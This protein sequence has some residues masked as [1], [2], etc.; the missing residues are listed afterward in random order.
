MYI[1]LNIRTDYSLLHSMIKIKDLVKFAKENDLKALTITDDNMFGAMEFYKECTLNNIK[2]IIGINIIIE[3]D[4]LVL[5]AKNYDGYVNLLKL[6]SI[7]RENGL[8]YDLLKEYNNNLICILP[9]KSR[10]IY[11]KLKDIY[12]DLYISYE[13]DLEKDKI[14]SANKLYMKEILSLKEEDT[15][16]LNYLDAIKNGKL[17]EH[18]KYDNYLIL[19]KEDNSFLYDK[20]DI[21]IDKKDNLLPHFDNS[22]NLLKQNCIDGLK[23]IFGD[24]VGSKYIERLK[25]ELDTINEMGFNDYF[26]IVS[27]YVRFAKENNILVGPGR[28]SAVG[29]LV[30]YVLGITEI[31]PLKYGLLFERFLNNKRITMPDIDIDFDGDKRKLV[32]KYCMDKYGF[33]NVAGVITFTTLGSK[34]VL[35]DVGRTLDIDVKEIEYLGKLLDSNLNLNENLKLDKIKNHLNKNSEL[36]ELYDICLKLEGIKKTT[37]VNASGIIICSQELDNFIPLERHDNMYLSG[38]SMNYLEDIG[39]LK[40]DF[41]ALKNLSTIASINSEVNINLYEIPLD[42]KETFEIFNNSNTLG[43]F[44]FET[45]GMI[46]VLRK[47]KINKFDDLYNLSAIFRPGPKENIDSYIKRKNGLERID[48]FDESLESI[49]KPTYGIIIYQEQIMKIANIMANYTLGEADI[50]RR[51]MSKKKEEILVNEKDKFI[52]RSISN[53]Y[54]KEKSET[55]YNLILKFAEY[56]FNK[57]HSVAYA[58]ISYQMAYLKAHYTD[59]FYK[60][61]LNSVM[62]SISSTKE[63][64]MEAKRLGV[65][66]INPSINLSTDSYKIDNGI[67]LPLNL[68]NGI[69]YNACKMILENRKDKYVDI[70]DFLAKMDL[71]I[72][73][74]DVLTNLILIGCFDEFNI[75]R[76]TLIENL[77]VIYNYI[78]LGS[79]FVL[80]PELIMYDEYTKK[81]LIKYE[82]EIFGFYLNNNPITEYRKDSNIKITLSNVTSYMTRV[83][84]VIVFIDE[85]KEIKSKKNEKMCFV[86]LSDDFSN[87][88]GVIFSNAY[89]EI[90]SIKVNDIVK[91]R[92]KIESRKG[93]TQIIVNKMELLD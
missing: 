49:L 43:I 39:L 34:A 70:Y 21:K 12:S 38:Y 13:N 66:F 44:Q 54:T 15:D 80:R 9:C 87:I 18:N 19:D 36:K 42:D 17:V 32:I 47:Y 11:N 82:F 71:K 83:I 89:N 30:A 81:E 2:P 8:T 25:T 92:G 85:I 40:M 58:L 77:D 74:K 75:N 37:S 84:D 67:I 16:Y 79:D 51:A 57:S 78:E 69:N 10:K 62:G 60:N 76:R 27:D 73:K 53:G 22:Y 56:G 1:P 7:Y 41:L 72:F 59:I 64:I 14:K 33:K 88:D 28:G 5:Y 48:C 46:D 65:K 86:K 50:L 91:V 55:I 35:K 24:S 68:I 29:S 61:L 4:S 93:K 45:D 52:K 6:S 23:R 26:L 3:D 20:I 90:P 31:D 63:Y